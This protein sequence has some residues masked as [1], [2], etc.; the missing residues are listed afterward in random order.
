[1]IGS[2]SSGEAAA[3]KLVSIGGCFSGIQ[4]LVDY[5]RVFIISHYPNIMEIL[6]SIYSVGEAYQSAVGASNQVLCQMIEY[7][8][9]IFLQ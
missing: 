1:M 8:F 7:Y 2:H 6:N 9:V 3:H 5:M 4:S